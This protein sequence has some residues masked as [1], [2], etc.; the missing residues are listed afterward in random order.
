MNEATWLMIIGLGFDI[1]GA[2]LIVSPLLNFIKKGKGKDMGQ[3]VTWFEP[4][5]LVKE[6]AF[7]SEWI[8]QK[9]ARIGLGCLGFGFFLQMVGNWLQNPPL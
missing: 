5:E 6:S 8:A 4:K 2:V 1:L 3:D 7:R 9:R